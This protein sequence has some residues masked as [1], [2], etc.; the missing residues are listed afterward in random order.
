MKLILRR[1][2]LCVPKPLAVPRL[3]QRL[4]SRSPYAQTVIPPEGLRL[5]HK[6]FIEAGKFADELRL[7]REAESAENEV[8]GIT[9]FEEHKI[10][11]A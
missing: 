7:K 10:V 9:N 11:S 5:D 3:L 2:A 6:Q 4:T 1:A 8:E